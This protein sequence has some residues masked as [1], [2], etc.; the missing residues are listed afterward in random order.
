MVT[1]KAVI[2]YFSLGCLVN[3]PQDF[4][5]NRNNFL[6]LIRYIKLFQTVRPNLRLH[7]LKDQNLSHRI[8]SQVSLEARSQEDLGW[9]LVSKFFIIIFGICL[10]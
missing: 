5:D 10:F 8:H 1:V 9:L 3:S 6:G 2:S 7:F 4:Y